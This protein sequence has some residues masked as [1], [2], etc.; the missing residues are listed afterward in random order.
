MSIAQL[1]GW[2]AKGA[3]VTEELS[4]AVIADDQA[5]VSYLL[6]Q[7]HASVAALDLQGESPL[8]GA[9]VQKSPGMV[10]LLIAHGA[11]VNQ[12]D[13]DGWTPLMQAAYTD[14]AADVKV[15]VAHGADP[16]AVNRQHLTALGIAV[17]VRARTTPPWH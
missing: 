16:N 7:K 1:N 14:D 10:A 12:R 2:L 5:R 17:A 8:H 15:L 6:D 9:L 11:D 4:D 13:R 3:N